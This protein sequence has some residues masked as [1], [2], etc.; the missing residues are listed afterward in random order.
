MRRAGRCRLHHNRAFPRLRRAS[1]V[2]ESKLNRT[3]EMMRNWRLPARRRARAL[4][5]GAGAEFAA[6][7]RAMS[8]T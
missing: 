8:Q 7:A 1:L 2:G 3:P 6:A 5:L 4:L